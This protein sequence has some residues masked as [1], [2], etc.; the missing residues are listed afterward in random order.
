M[1][2]DLNVSLDLE[3]AIAKR[4]SD[5]EMDDLVDELKGV[6]SNSWKKSTRAALIEMIRALQKLSGPVTAAE[7]EMAERMIAV[8]LNMDL[9]TATKKNLVDIQEAAYLMG[10]GEAAKGTGA[11]IAWGLADQKALDV[12][13]NNLRFWIGSYYD[14]NLQEGFKA[15]LQDYFEGGYNRHEISLLMRDHFKALGNRGL[16]YW[17]LLADHTVTKTRE[18]GRV[19][20]YEQAMVET[21]RVKARLDD[22]TTEVCRR[23]HG[24]VIAVKDIRSQVDGYFKACQ[25]RDKNKIRASWP[26]W[27]DKD[28]EKKMRGPKSIHR[29]VKRG[30]VGLPPYHARCRT[31]TVSEFFGKP[32]DHMG[33]FFDKKKP[34]PINTGKK[35]VPKKNPKVPQ[36]IGLLGGVKTYADVKQIIINKLGHLGKFNPISVVGIQA[37]G[38]AYMFTHSAGDVF[39]SPRVFTSNVPDGK[40]A[41]VSVKWAPS[42]AVLS[43]FSKI[44]RG[45]QLE[46]IE[47][48]S[49]ESLWHEIQHNRQNQTHTSFI[50][51]GN[52]DPRRRL[53]EVVNQWTARRT[54]PDMLKVLGAKAEH[55]K[56]VKEHGLGYRS[57]VR[58]FGTLLEKLGVNDNSILKDMVD[59]NENH[60][61]WTF[62]KPLV[63]LLHKKQ[64]T[65]YGKRDIG[66][67]VKYITIES[68]KSYRK[69][70][71]LV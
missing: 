60:P 28:A 44:D 59:M 30:K 54:Y 42:K 18:I 24:H 49:L 19:S 57:W 35:T 12:L 68:E 65:K 22:R 51:P 26:W 64:T 13:D 23:L 21:I 69:Y 52:N 3:I 29:L 56:D 4:R 36:K 37:D 2:A 25:T 67:F 1:F 38:S 15:V 70:L 53:M 10:A 55:L 39:L 66:K 9:D 33:D 7:L 43:A 16:S 63:D 17:D 11:R 6:L 27:S 50:P 71:E 61:R 40:G 14:D 58:N 48:Y 20:G 32:G 47:E 5:L 8:M 45:E 34:L 46:F 62:R 31:I 41:K